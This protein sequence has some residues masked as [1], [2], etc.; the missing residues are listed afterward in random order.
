MNVREA[1][2]KI[3]VLGA[4]SPTTLT[5]LL[6]HCIIRRHN[7]GEHLFFDKEYVDHIYFMVSGACCLYKLS[8]DEEKRGIFIYGTGAAINEVI[9][10][11]RPASINCE[12][13]IDSETLSILRPQFL[14]ACEQDFALT[15]A[16]MN[17]MS[18]KIRR[19]YH[20][21]KNTGNTV[22]GDRRI[23]AKLWKLSRDFGV[24]CPQGVKI[25]FELSIT[26]LAELLGSKRETV[27]RQVKM[28]ADAGLVIV[29]KRYFIIP[30]REKLRAYYT[31]A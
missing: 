12:F 31:K 18:L 11:E 16:V 15:Q 13:L 17:S 3:G 30:D 20:M 7:R 23:A 29:E 5:A 6:P 25:G 1:I 27:S 8:G 26:F 24:E 22:R 21:I 19:L 2:E 4:A 14:L 9:L 28:L 10:D